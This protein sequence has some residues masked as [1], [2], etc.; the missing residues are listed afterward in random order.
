M[1]Q[2][3]YEEGQ[4]VKGTVSQILE[5]GAVVKLDPGKT[6]LLH[7]REIDHERKRINAFDEFEVGQRLTGVI[8]GEPGAKLR[9]GTKRYYFE[10]ARVDNEEIDRI[11]IENQSERRIENE[12][13]KRKFENLDAEKERIDEIIED[14]VEDMQIEKKIPSADVEVQPIDEDSDEE[15]SDETKIEGPTLNISHNFSSEDTEMKMSTTNQSKLIMNLKMK[16]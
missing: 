4:V 14:A 12:A 3:K 8:I 7:V 1:N 16:R 11:I 5:F 15:L 2:H 10:A 9:L 6:A 13:K